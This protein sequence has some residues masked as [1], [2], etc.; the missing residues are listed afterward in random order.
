MLLR[1]PTIS[2]T[3]QEVGFFPTMVYFYLW[4]VKGLFGPFVA[5]FM[6]IKGLFSYF[7]GW[8]KGPF[9]YFYRLI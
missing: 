2:S 4:V 9:G 6:A 8:F 7:Y 1:P 3:L 5:D